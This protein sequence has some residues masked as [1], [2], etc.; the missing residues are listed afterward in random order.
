MAEDAVLG[1]RSGALD[2]VG[3]ELEDAADVVGLV[4]A[5]VDADEGVAGR[6]GEAFVGGSRDAGKIVARMIGLQARREAAGEAER[7]ARCG[8]DCAARGLRMALA[9]FPTRA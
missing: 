4:D 8:D 3:G 1:R 7:I 5:R 9:R 6:V 2:D